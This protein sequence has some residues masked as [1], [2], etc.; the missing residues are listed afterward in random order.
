MKPIFRSRRNKSPHNNEESEKKEAPFFMKEN[1]SPFF[2]TT[3]ETPVQAKLTVGQPGDKY[4]KEADTMADAVVDNSSKPNIQNKAIS[5]IQRESLATP[6]EDEKLGTAEQRMEKDKLIQEKPE[7]QRMEGEEEEGMVNK[8]EGEEEEGMVNK[9]EGEKEEEGMVNKME[10]EEEEGAVQTKSGTANQ[11]TSKGLSQQIKGK[12]GNGRN[13]SKS[14]QAEMETSFGTDFS[15]VNI[16]TDQDSVQMNKEL[17]AQAFTHGKDVYFNSGKYNPDSSRGKHLLAHELTHVVQQG[18]SDLRR[19]FIQKQNDEANKTPEKKGFDEAK[20]FAIARKSAIVKKL[21]ADV[22]KKQGFKYAGQVSGKN[23]YTIC[24]DTKKIYIQKEL[25]DE[26]AAMR[27]AYELQNAANC[28]KYNQIAKKAKEGK[29]KSAADY[30]TD[31]LMVEVFALI[32]KARVGLELGIA[33]T[34]IIENL[35]KSRDKNEI[36]QAELEKKI[37]TVVETRGKIDGMSAREYYEKQF[38]D[39]GFK[40]SK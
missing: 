19:K 39:M 30:A 29:Y 10:G 1:K 22:I 37:L 25:S 20:M 5:S 16:H 2:N 11:T 21:E 3:T 36:S 4:E 14:T 40:E 27:Y 31:T 34:K 8:M 15:E 33:T 6:L 13:L 18:G 32:N 7:I 24:G 26:Q 28:S 17:G 9:M 12:A 23:S 35:V 38:K